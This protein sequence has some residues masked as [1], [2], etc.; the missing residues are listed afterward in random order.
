[1]P[2]RTVR[3]AR[4]TGY[5]LFSNVIFGLAVYFSYLGLS[6]YS[7]LLAYFGN[8]ALIALALAI[9]EYSIRLLQ[10]RRLFEETKADH[11][12]LR[13]LVDSFVSFKTVLYLF[14]ILVLVL[15]QIVD[16]YPSLVGGQLG[17]F[18][19]ANRYSVVL[20]VAFDKLIGQ[21]SQDREKREAVSAK[22]DQYLAEDGHR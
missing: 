8:L 17:G 19:L 1:M 15:S 12:Q 4:H 20:V 18:L 10:S 7:L 3:I 11:R 16:F 14:Y 9:D 2:S 6:R 22:L 13:L 5:A 21:F